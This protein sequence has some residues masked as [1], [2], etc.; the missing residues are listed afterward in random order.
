MAYRSLLCSAVAASLI[1]SFAPSA[2]AFWLIPSGNPLH[3]TPEV[4]EGTMAGLKRNLDESPLSDLFRALTEMSSDIGATSTMAK[5]ALYRGMYLRSTD[6]EY[7]LSLDVP[8]LHVNELKVVAERGTLSLKGDHE[9]PNLT[10][11]N[12]PDPLC[13]ERHYDSRFTL[14]SDADEESAVAR[15]DAG[16][17]SVR[18]PKIKGE[19]RGVGRVLQLSEDAA[20]WVYDKTG[21]RRAVEEVQNGYEWSK[22]QVAKASDNVRENA[23]YAADR[24]RGTAEDA[25]ESARLNAEYAARRAKEGGD[26]VSESARDAAYRAAAAVRDA[27]GKVNDAARNAAQAGSESARSV[28]SAV[29]GTAQSAATAAS[30]AAQQAAN[31]AR[32][33]ASR[34]TETAKVAADKAEATEGKGFFDRLHDTVV[35]PIKERVHGTGGKPGPAAGNIPV[36][37]KEEL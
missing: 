35:N 34:A 32:S 30:D 11:T 26:Y 24:V 15:L 19:R 23:Q 4:Q 17:V 10:A 21:V 29:S 22:E 3:R 25:A 14:P 13:I 9:C 7:V 1:L 8:G 28:A 27:G 5:S 18:V 6:D 31:S 2:D 20:G 16:V 36:E 12:A 37:H 33:A